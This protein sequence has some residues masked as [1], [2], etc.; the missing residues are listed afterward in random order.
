MVSKNDIV[1]LEHTLGDLMSRK[2]MDPYCRLEVYPQILQTLRQIL[3]MREKY[4]FD[5]FSERITEY[6]SE[7]KGD[8]E[9]WEEVVQDLHR[10]GGIGTSGS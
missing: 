1:S 8:L 9:Y 10:L 7:I 5:N 4:L 2:I 6:S 3:V